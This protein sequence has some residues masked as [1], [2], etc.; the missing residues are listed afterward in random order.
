ML[1]LFASKL[2]VKIALPS[3]ISP[4]WLFTKRHS[5][6]CYIF[7]IDKS[8]IFCLRPSWL[9][10]FLLWFNKKPHA[11]ILQIMFENLFRNK[12]STF[13]RKL[14]RLSNINW[15]SSIITTFIHWIWLWFHNGF[16]IILLG[17]IKSYRSI[18]CKL[19]YATSWTNTISIWS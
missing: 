11:P 9:L 13:R 16:I 3:S 1:Q 18:M 19:P 12:F 17:S 5:W 7:F 15:T 10:I 4:T 2:L 6:Y 8:I 14:L